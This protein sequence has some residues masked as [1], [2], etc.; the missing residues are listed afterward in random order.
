MSISAQFLCKGCGNTESFK[1]QMIVETKKIKDKNGEVKII[2]SRWEQGICNG[3]GSLAADLL[4]IAKRETKKKKVY[5]S[6]KPFSTFLAGSLGTIYG[7]SRGKDYVYDLVKDR[8]VKRGRL[9]KVD[10]SYGLT[11]PS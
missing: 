3:C 4:E 7:F 11:M 8:I 2:R 1:T 9:K 10:K 6:T 5:W